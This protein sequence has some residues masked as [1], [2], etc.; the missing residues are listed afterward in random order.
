MASRVKQVRVPVSTVFGAAL[1]V[2]LIPSLGMHLT[3]VDPG[4][5]LTIVGLI[6]AVVLPLGIEF[7]N[8]AYRP[9]RVVILDYRAHQYGHAVARG[10]MRTLNADTRQWIVEYKTPSDTTGES[11]AWQIRELQSA[12]INDLDGLV[13]IPAEDSR[14]LWFALA[15]AA[16]TG[17]FIVVADTKPPN[18]IFRN[19]GLEPPRFVSTRYDRTGVLIG[20]CLVDWMKEHADRQAVLW[21]GPAKSYPGEE[22]SRNVLFQLAEANLVNRTTLLP[23]AS[24]A[25]SSELCRQT[26]KIVEQ[27]PG[28]VAVY[29][30]DD[31]NAMSLHWLTVADNARLREH[32]F[33]V[34]CNATPDDWGQV[35]A[36]AMKTVDA[37]VDILAEEQGAQ[38]ALLMIKERSG[39]LPSSERSV[40][41]EPE[42]VLPGHGSWL[43]SLFV[44]EHDVPADGDVIVTVIQDEHGKQT[45]EIEPETASTDNG[46][47]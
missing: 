10:A 1:L 2:A 14:D 24:W 31:E 40:Y 44:A 17:M 7:R 37:T 8:R 13:L 22:R 38:A 21:T 23:M 36:V 3:G 11:L 45:M 19:V 47:G 25:P 42:L 18:S 4:I 34:G 39:K 43:E 30:A 28:E 35:P 32:M 20:E 12:V 15:A 16:K 27:A 41:I 6:L 26:L 9:R 5:N 33:I 29:C 46:P